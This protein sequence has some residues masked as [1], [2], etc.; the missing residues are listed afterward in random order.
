MDAPFGSSTERSQVPYR[1]SAEVGP[2]AYRLP[3]SIKKA[4]PAFVPFSST[5]SELL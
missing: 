4:L 2:G 5:S 3:A 1:T